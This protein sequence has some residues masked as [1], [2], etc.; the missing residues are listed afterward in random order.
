M[1]TKSTIHYQNNPQEE[2]VNILLEVC[3]EILLVEEEVMAHG[4]AEVAIKT[5]LVHLTEPKMVEHLIMFYLGT[6]CID[7]VF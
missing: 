6:D 4:E 3:R 2:E 5:D 7:T 1:R